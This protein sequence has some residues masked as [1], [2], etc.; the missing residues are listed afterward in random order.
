MAR[1]W[2]RWSL[3]R[4]RANALHRLVLD[5]PVWTLVWSGP[6][7]REWGFDIPGKGWTHWRSAQEAWERDRAGPNSWRGES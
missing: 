5:R 1:R 4:R 6:K 2:P 7:V 3:I